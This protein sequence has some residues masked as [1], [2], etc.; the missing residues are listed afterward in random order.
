MVSPW[1][2]RLLVLALAATSLVSATATLPYAEPRS[3]NSTGKTCVVEP[4]PKRCRRD[5]VP[6]ILEAFRECNHGGTV[7]FPEG[8]EYYIAQRLNPTLYDVTIE[9]R[10]TWLVRYRTPPRPLSCGI[11]GYVID[12]GVILTT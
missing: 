3:P 11:S 4:S 2:S 9:W 5:D 7:V 1:L 6:R 8:K 12:T 10:G